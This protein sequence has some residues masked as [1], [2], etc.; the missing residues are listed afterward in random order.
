MMAAGWTGMHAQNETKVQSG[1]GVGRT[2]L[3]MS[4]GTP[5]GSYALNS[6]ESINLFSGKVNIAVPV[7]PIGGRGESGYTITVP[8]ESRSWTV[9]VDTNL[10]PCTEGS[11]TNYTYAAGAEWTQSGTLY[12]AWYGPG[13]LLAKRTGIQ[14]LICTGSIVMS[15]TFTQVVFLGPD[16]TEHALLPKNGSPVQTNTCNGPVTE[17]RGTE[18]MT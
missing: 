17:A 2:P 11:C 16:G 6:I 13:M 10:E 3:V 1:P 12:K 18:F 15:Q 8:I 14:P 7:L 5:Q 9:Q 4:P